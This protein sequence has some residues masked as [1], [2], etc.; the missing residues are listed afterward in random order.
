ML[1]G[2]ASFASGLRL[3][4]RR[5]GLALFAGEPDIA[6]LLREASLRASGNV[7]D[8]AAAIF[9]ASALRSRILGPVAVPHR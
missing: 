3:L 8:E 1:P 9:F 6:E 7:A 2:P 4:A 5:R